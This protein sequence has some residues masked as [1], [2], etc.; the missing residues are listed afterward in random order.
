[1]PAK[2]HQTVMQFYSIPIRATKIQS[3]FSTISWQK[4]GIPVLASIAGGNGNIVQ[5]LRR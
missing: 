1:M 5:F 3:K 2:K 4:C